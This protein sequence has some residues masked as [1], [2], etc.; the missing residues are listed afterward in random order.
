MATEEYTSVWN[1]P[2]RG[3]RRE[4]PALTQ[5]QIVAEAIKLLDAD[6]LEALTMRK[7]GAALGAVATAVYWHVANKEE[8]LELVVDEVHGE[9]EVPDV[10]DASQWRDAAEAS[11]RSLRSMI[12]RHPWVAPTLA[13]VGMNYLGP[14]L[15][16]VSDEML[17]IYLTAGFELLEAD[18]ASKTVLG[19]V[20]GIASVEA[21]TISKLHRSGKE[22]AEWQA[23][24]WPAAVQAAEPYSRMRALYA[25]YGGADLQA[26]A[27][28]GF[29][30]GLDR[31]LD[32]LEARLGRS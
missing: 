28:D 17:G 27:E 22:M 1:R 23:A 8:L 2:K 10:A 12:V 29:S 25:A 11:A 20:I 5:D 24:V 19:Y 30:Y 21:A 16:R 7:L 32:G 26:G 15:M 4:Q 14:N 6:G 3:R 9:I 13:D 18:Q 31:I